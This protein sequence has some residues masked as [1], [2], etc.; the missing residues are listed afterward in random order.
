MRKSHLQANRLVKN[1]T[2][3]SVESTITTAKIHFPKVHCLS[4]LTCAGKPAEEPALNA[5]GSRLR[6]P[7]LVASK[8]P[9]RFCSKSGNDQIRTRTSDWHEREVSG[10]DPLNVSSLMIEVVI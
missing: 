1:A 9:C 8:M 3:C 4:S 10:G 7:G 2:A 6:P 5:L